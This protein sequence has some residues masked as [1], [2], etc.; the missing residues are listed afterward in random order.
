[1]RK[2]I[3]TVDAVTIQLKS[4]VIKHKVNSTARLLTELFH[5]LPKLAKMITKNIFLGGSEMVTAGG[6]ERL[7]LLL[8]HVDQEGE[9]GRVSPKADY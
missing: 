8:G 7:N 6:L 5:T 2:K 1:M 4:S 9:I 3:R